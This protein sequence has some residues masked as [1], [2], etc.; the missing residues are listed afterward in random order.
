[1]RSA[2]CSTT[3]RF[4]EKYGPCHLGPTQLEFSSRSEDAFWRVWS[5]SPL[6]PGNPRHLRL[7]HLR[8]QFCHR[9]RLRWVYLDTIPDFSFQ[10][11]TPRLSLGFP[12]GANFFYDI[13]AR[14]LRVGFAYG[15]NHSPDS[16]FIKRSVH[17]CPFT[18]AAIP[19]F[20]GAAPYVKFDA[21][22]A[23]KFSNFLVKRRARLPAVRRFH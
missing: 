3:S 15:L 5:G 2:F 22:A 21:T 23:L 18:S 10:I 4:P 20:V 16:C 6:N 7:N 12:A 17:F 13:V 19:G 11:L 1:M 8:D 14:D 9:L